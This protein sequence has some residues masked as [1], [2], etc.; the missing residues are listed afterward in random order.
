[1]TIQHNSIITPKPT[2]ALLEE[3]EEYWDITLP[4]D[5]R[6][7]I[8]EYN[9]GVPIEYAFF[10]S[11]GR[12]RDVNR[13]LCVLDEPDDHPDGWYD[14]NVVES[15]ISWRLTSNPDLVGMDLLPIADLFFGNY[16]CLD[17]RKDRANP[18][19]CI[20][21]HEESDDYSPVTYPVADNFTEFLGMLT[22]PEE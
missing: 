7:F 8:M 12:E 14:I 6:N 16:L 21:E 20:W 3:M 19:V 15:P 13:F 9:G 10:L 4:Q 17:F 22:L 11:D 18:T 5:Y 2:P 1:M